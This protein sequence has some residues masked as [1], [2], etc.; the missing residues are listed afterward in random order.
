MKSNFRFVDVL[1]KL[2]EPEGSSS[3]DE[4]PSQDTPV[5][6]EFDNVGPNPICYTIRYHL[7]IL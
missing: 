2:Y 7:T 1:V 6:L 4:G 3:I 5:P